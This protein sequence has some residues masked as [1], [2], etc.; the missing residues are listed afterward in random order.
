MNE[1]LIFLGTVRDSGWLVLCAIFAVAAAFFVLD[2]PAKQPAIE[3]TEAL[4]ER[5]AA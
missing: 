1:I 5:K 4:P 3:H 2:R